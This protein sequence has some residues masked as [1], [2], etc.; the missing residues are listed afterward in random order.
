LYIPIKGFRTV[1]NL[2]IKRGQPNFGIGNI[3]RGDSQDVPIQYDQVSQL[4]GGR[5]A[6]LSGLA[7][8][9]RRA[10][11]IAPHRFGD[12][13][14]LGRISTTGRCSV[15]PLPGHGSV[16]A[17]ERVR[18]SDR[19]IRAERQHH[20]GIQQITESVITRMG[21]LLS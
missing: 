18:G 10:Q 11:R 2:A 14:A 19:T 7:A 5:A 16:N 20:A 3:L 12:G 6:L 13:Q 4:T 15:L 21:G 1:D 8:G 17:P 9:V